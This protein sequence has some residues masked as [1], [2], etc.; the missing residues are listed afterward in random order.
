MENKVMF[1]NS[2][3]TL[4]ILEASIKTNFFAGKTPQQQLNLMRDLYQHC[5]KEDTLFHFFYEPDIII[6]I[7]SE[8]VLLKAKEFL[9]K[10]E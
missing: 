7:T 6:C 10:K 5:L 1:T 8:Q 2:V 4:H 3:K 9:E